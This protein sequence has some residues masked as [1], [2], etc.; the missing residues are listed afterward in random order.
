MSGPGYRQPVLAL[1]FACAAPP[2]P[3]PPAPPAVEPEPPPPWVR[4]ARV[5]TDG[6]DSPSL[7]PSL[8]GERC[9]A[10]NARIGG[11][12]PPCAVEDWGG[13]GARRVERAGGVLTIDGTPGRTTWT[14]IN[15][16]LEGCLGDTLSLPPAA[17]PGAT[18][19]MT[20]TA[21]VLTFSGQNRCE[22]GGELTLDIDQ[23][24]AEWSRLT[25][26]GLP[27]EKGGRDHAK[28]TH[29][30]RLRAL[31]RDEWGSLSQEEREDALR[32]L[33]EDPHPEAKT[34]LKRR[35]RSMSRVR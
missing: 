23:D 26:G 14:A 15:G 30:A 31:V 21:W 10:V 24:H 33:A 28:S 9:A 2:E 22:L 34:L 35:Q 27:W 1:V 19:S 13:P 16:T 7:S 32:A 11:D 3:T 5:S 29:R 25:A 18:R 17:D 12:G 4:L 20:E 8:L 6:I